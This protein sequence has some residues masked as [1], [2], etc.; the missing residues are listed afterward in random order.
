M[1]Y[2]GAVTI[3]ARVKTLIGKA[4]KQKNVPRKRLKA[5]AGE[6]ASSKRSLSVRSCTDIKS[7]GGGVRRADLRFGEV[8]QANAF[9]LHDMHGSDNH[10]RRLWQDGALMRPR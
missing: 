10:Q 9:G 1:E 5:L 3:H 7:I 4:P 8:R 2:S 6:D